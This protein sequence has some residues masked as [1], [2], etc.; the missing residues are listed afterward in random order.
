[1]KE[2]E[3]AELWRKTLRGLQRA[4]VDAG[5]RGK[6]LMVRVGHLTEHLAG[7]ST[8]LGRESGSAGP[9]TYETWLSRRPSMRPNPEAG[10]QSSEAAG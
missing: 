3:A 9:G 7:S 10:Q 2:H 6:R 5:S 1:M 4:V 8:R